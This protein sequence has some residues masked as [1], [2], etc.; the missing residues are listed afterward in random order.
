MGGKDAS[1][2]AGRLSRGCQQG[3]GGG[4]AASEEEG[5]HSASASVGLLSSPLLRASSGFPL[6]LGFKLL[7]ALLPCEDLAEVAP[8]YLSSLITPS[9]FLLLNLHLTCYSVVHPYW[10]TCSL[11]RALFSSAE[12][13]YVCSLCSVC[14]SHPYP[15]YPSYFHFYIFPSRDH[16]PSHPPVP[17]MPLLYT[18][19]TLFLLWHFIIKQLK[20]DGT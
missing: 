4:R 20:K 12:S 8:V 14:H 2:E 7:P 16:S 6:P 15:L 19:G 17:N 3:L 9:T 18:L 10:I 5:L 1:P 13:F 11:W